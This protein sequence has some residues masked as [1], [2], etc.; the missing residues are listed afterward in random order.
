MKRILNI[1]D[2]MV[3]EN[4]ISEDNR[5][6]YR[7]GIT[8]GLLYLVNIVTFLGIGLI[9]ETFW[10]VLIYIVCYVFIRSYAGGYHSETHL[11]CYFFSSGMVGSIALLMRYI[12]INSYVKMAVGCLTVIFLLLLS[13]VEDVHKPLDDLEKK[14]YH[15]RLCKIVGI[16]GLIFIFVIVF[17]IELFSTAIFWAWV[18]GLW[19]VVLGRVK[20]NHLEI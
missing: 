18:S 16:E 9:L 3:E 12:D 10:G 5:E 19:M 6:V 15:Q 14:V 8:H 7:F 4:I 2:W 13:P 20:N 1:V 17:D 11:G